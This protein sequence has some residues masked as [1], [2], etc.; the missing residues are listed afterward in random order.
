M[1]HADQVI[2]CDEGE[3]QA[4]YSTSAWNLSFSEA[5]SW[6]VDNDDDKTPR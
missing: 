1:I 6:S 5:S 3:V 4:F 2:I